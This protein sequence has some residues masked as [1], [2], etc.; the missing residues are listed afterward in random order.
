MTFLLKTSAI[1]LKQVQTTSSKPFLKYGAYLA[2]II[3]VYLLYKSLLEHGSGEFLTSSKHVLDQ[4]SEVARARDPTCSYWDCFNVYRCGQQRLLVYVYPNARDFVDENGNKADKFT[5]EFYVMLQTI[6]N[7]RYYTSNPNEACIFVPSIDMLSQANINIDLVNKALAALP[8]WENGQNHLLFNFIAGASPDYSTV[9]DVNTDKALI[10]GAGFDTW[11]YRMGFDVSIPFYSPLLNEFRFT[12]QNYGQRRPHLLVSPQLNLFSKHFRVLQE[13]AYDYPEL[14]LLQKCPAP[15][16][17]QDSAGQKQPQMFH[18]DTRCNFPNG[19]E[20]DYPQILEKATFCLI[21]RGVRLSQPNF[22]EAMAAGCIPV[23]MADNY[24]MPFSEIL[25][26]NLASIQIREGDLHSVMSVLKAVSKQKIIELQKHVK[27]FYDRYFSS[28]EK[29]TMTVLDELND[30]VFPHLAKD[31]NYWNL[32]SNSVQNPLFL[33]IIAPQSQGFTAVILTYDRVESLF[34]LIQ[35]LAV[36]PSLQKI[37]VIWNNQKKAPP[38]IN[39][40]PKISKP[41][42]VI[43]TKANKLSNRFY[44]Y[45][46]IETE[47]ILTIDDDIVML[48]AD[49]LDFGYEVWREHY[50]RIVGFPS[51]THVWDNVTEKWRYESEWTNQISM[52]L[53]GAAFHHK[54]WSYMYTNAMPGDIKEWVDEHMNCEDIAMNFLVANITNK[55]PIKVTPRKKFKCP[56]CTNTEMLSADLNHMMERSACI[57]RFAKIYGTMPLKSVEFRADPVLFKDNFPEKLKRFNDIGNL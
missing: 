2:C 33:P 20:F 32:P 43:Q 25:D 23:V 18:L 55:P 44:P 29:I 30:R 45:E 27:F 10:A 26:W 38:H 22:I 34:T 40:F 31:Y 39:H 21:A 37:L 36:V 9:M 17:G 57:N 8:Y 41:L 53:T 1:N 4:D 24:V 47:A 51:R 15:T 14:L 54:Y 46:D 49:E 11:T 6:I 16:T 56:E 48:T 12:N 42:K 52:V 35:K 5:K 3:I 50:D 7:S 19:R 13:L 28:L